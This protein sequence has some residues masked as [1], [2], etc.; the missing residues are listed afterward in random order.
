VDRDGRRGFV[1]TLQTREQ[2]IR[3]EKATPNICTNQGL[4]ALRATIYLG[5]SASSG[6]AE[7][8]ELCVQKAHHAAARAARARLQAR[9]RG[10]FFR[11]FVLECPVDA[12]EVVRGRARTRRDCRGRSGP[13]P[14]R[15]AALA[16]GRGHRAAH[17][18]DIERWLQRSRAAGSRPR[19]EVVKRPAA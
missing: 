16:A 14:P 2:H 1:L 5:C 18:A 17:A 12:A 13:V 9:A 19:E 15:M 7:V 4:L 10:P 3:R 6:T 11:E 8:A